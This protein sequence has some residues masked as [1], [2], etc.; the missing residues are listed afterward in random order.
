M[1]PSSVGGHFTMGFIIFYFFIKQVNDHAPPFFSGV[2][3]ARSLVFR[4]MVCYLFL[5]F[6][7]FAMVLSLF[8]TCTASGYTSDIL[9]LFYPFIFN[10]SV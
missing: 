4:V 6:L 8:L 1:C 7:I 3:V 9:K 10:Y 5:I 2:R